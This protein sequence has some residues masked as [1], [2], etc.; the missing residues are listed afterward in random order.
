MKKLLFLI[1]L[2]GFLVVLGGSAFAAEGGG[3][4]KITVETPS[5][6]LKAV[7]K[8]PGYLETKVEKP[9]TGSLKVREK[10]RVV[11]PPRPPS[12]IVEIPKKKTSANKGFI[13]ADNPLVLIPALTPWYFQLNKAGASIAMQQPIPSYPTIV[14][15]KIRARGDKEYSKAKESF[16][17]ASLDKD[18][19]N[20]IIATWVYSETPAGMM[21]DVPFHVI[22]YKIDW[23]HQE[24]TVDVN[25]LSLNDDA[26]KR[27]TAKHVAKLVAVAPGFSVRVG[28]VD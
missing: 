10:I 2:A 26:T 14:E 17:Q 12:I 11:I 8:T 5:L 22:R 23:Y 13:S 15:V 28:T 20:R 18:I 21:G 1:L 4:K 25:G 16:A 24:I 19:A 27:R 3:E 9:D 7:I 6:N